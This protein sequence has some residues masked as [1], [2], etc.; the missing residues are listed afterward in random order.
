MLFVQQSIQTKVALIGTIH[1][2]RDRIKSYGVKELGLFGSF[3]KDDQINESSDVDFLVDFENGKKSYDNF[4][5]LSFFL[6]EI[7]GRKVEL[8]TAQSLS[9]YLGP[10]ILRQVEYV[11]I[12]H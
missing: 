8:V 10:H 11:S 7:L 2:N 9:K 12:E 5:D 1:E 4:M 3:V 6:E